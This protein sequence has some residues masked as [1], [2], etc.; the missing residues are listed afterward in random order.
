MHEQINTTPPT[1][2][3]ESTGQS[4]DPGDLSNVC[5]Q[6]TNP[7]LRTPYP[8]QLEA[9]EDIKLNL[10]IN[11]K[12]WIGVACGA[13]K[14]EVAN[15]VIKDEELA[16]RTVASF[17]PSIALIDQTLREWREFGDGNSEFI[18]CA[19]DQDIGKSKLKK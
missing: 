17:F 7:T 10:V 4:L 18:V 8:Y 13:G 6:Q 2:L 1:R 15:L 16:V 11:G 5:I 3:N 19:S 12:T 14:T 9:L